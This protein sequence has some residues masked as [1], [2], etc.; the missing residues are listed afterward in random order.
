MKQTHTSA[1][2]SINAA[3]LPRVYSVATFTPGEVI[4]DYGCGRYTDH[5]REALPAGCTYLPFDPYNQPNSV[6]SRSK[7]ALYRAIRAGKPVT[8]VCSNVLNVIDSAEVV[9]MVAA[10]IE[11]IVRK[12]GGRALIA[13]YEGDRTGTGRETKA[14]CY[15]RN[16]RT[17]EYMKWFTGPARIRRGLIEIQS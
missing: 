11:E 14:D 12:S 8:V 17:A 10:Q 9:A 3:K 6:N 7:A 5:I 16:E 2:T 1:A 15:Q 13:I 4:L